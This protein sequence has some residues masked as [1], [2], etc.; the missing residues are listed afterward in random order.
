MGITGNIHGVCGG[1]IEAVLTRQASLVVKLV[2]NPPAVQET[3][4]QFW[5]REDPLEKG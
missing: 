4:V 3:P 5:G 1:L 2:E